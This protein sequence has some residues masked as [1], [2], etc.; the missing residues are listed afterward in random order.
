VVARRQVRGVLGDYLAKLSL[1]T[2]VVTH[3]A[4]DARAL[5]QRFAVLEAGSIVQTGSWAELAA[6]PASAFVRELVSSGE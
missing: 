3:A 5:G 6:D 1:P 4:A 2:I